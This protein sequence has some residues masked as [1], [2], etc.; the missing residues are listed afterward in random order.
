MGLP[1]ACTGDMAEP[2]QLDAPM[3]AK[4]ALLPLQPSVHRAVGA[5]PHRMPSTPGSPKG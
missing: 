5:Q 2:R 3:A 1:V 4:A